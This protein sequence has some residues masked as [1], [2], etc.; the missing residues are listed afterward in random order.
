MYEE[1]HKLK[2]EHENRLANWEAEK[3]ANVE[4]MWEGR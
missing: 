1:F 4:Q 3:V 2:E